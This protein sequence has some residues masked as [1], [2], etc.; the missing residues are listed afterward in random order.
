[1]TAGVARRSK[2]SARRRGLALLA[3]PVIVA[4]VLALTTIGASA[5][6]SSPRGHEH[7]RDDGRAAVAWPVYGHDLAN[8]RTNTRE[9][10]VNRFTAGRL[11]PSWSIDGLVG[12]TGT[13]VVAGNV[14]YFDDWTGKLRAV[15]ARTGRPIWTSNVGGN[16]AA[17]PAVSRDTV[18]AASGATLF[19]FDRATGALRWKTVTDPDPF[20]QISAS[21]V[22]VGHLVFQGVA[23]IGAVVPSTHYT[24][25][26]SIAAYDVSTGQVVWRFFSTPNDATSGPGVGIWSTPAVDR[27]RGVLYVGTGQTLAAPNAPLSDSLLAIDYR[28]G[29]LVWSRQFTAPDIFSA[30]TPTGPDAD[31]GAS[32]N[33]WRADGRDL[34]GVGDKAGVYHALDRRTGKLVWQRPLTPRSSFGGVIGTAAVVDGR[35][36]VP[37]NVGNPA[38]NFPTNVT[39]VFALDPGSGVERWVVDL[40]GKILGPISAV[41]GVAFVGTD[42]GLMVAL[43][44]RTGTRLWSYQAPDKTA[45]G[46]SIVDGRVLWGYGFILFGPAGKG[47]VISFTVGGR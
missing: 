2:W 22:V 8:T 38:T 42:T 35:I 32:P 25:R 34:V 15:D 9:H 12:V 17:A 6:D 19:A 1:M 13:P 39:K 41:H 23:N 24:A 46:P 36:L 47:G 27:D 21:P 5:T 40:P 7:D 43:G 14:A 30:T 33:M 44:T 28:T 18:F 45:C 11:A 31:A 3:V 4:T 20:A 37:S 29:R 10:A 26:G 16:I